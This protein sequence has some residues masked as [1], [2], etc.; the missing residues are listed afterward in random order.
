MKRIP[1]SPRDNWEQKILEQGFLF[2]KDDSYYN[3]SAVYEFSYSEIALIEKATADIYDMCLKV[4]EHIIKNR[5]LY[6]R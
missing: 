6:S 3:E 2:Y 5:L 1:I 4:A